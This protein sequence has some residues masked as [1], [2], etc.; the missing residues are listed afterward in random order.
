MYFSKAA[1]AFSAMMLLGTNCWAQ[2][3]LVIYPN[4]GQSREQ[5]DK[6]NYECYGWAKQ[7]S[8]FDP[9]APP[10]ASTPPPQQ[11][12]AKGGVGRGALRGAAI[13]GI[14]DGSDGAKT[15]AAAGAVIGGVRRRDQR[16]QQAVAEQ[17][18]AQQEAAQYQ[19]GRN[20]Y[21]RAF[22]ACMEGRGYTV[23]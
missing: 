21:N 14:V 10:K 1:I 19:A 6:D 3:E 4:K 23:R 17:Q 2:G 8:G 22:A 16:R 7:Q 18:W 12:A 11:Q 20:D 9:M 5:Q 13:G 15:G